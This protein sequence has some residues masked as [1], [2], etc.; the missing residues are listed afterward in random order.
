MNNNLTTTSGPVSGV[1]FFTHSL[2]LGGVSTHMA[3]L[4]AGLM[5][6]GI[7]V[8]IAARELAPGAGF[9]VEYFRDR[10]FEIFQTDFAGYGLTP[11]NLRATWGSVRKVREVVRTF[12]PDLIHV[13]AP[14]LCLVARACGMPYVTTFNIQ[15]DGA[16]KRRIARVANRLLP[17]A[18]GEVSIA[19]S[20][21]LLADMRDGLG[22]PA[23]RI[24][25]TVYTVDE[26]NF[27]PAT[28]E[29]RAAARAHY[30]LPADA[31]VV[32][33]LAAVEPRKNH[34]LLLDALAIAK[35]KGRPIHALMAG[36]DFARRRDELTAKIER[37]GLVDLAR[38]MKHE[39]AVRLYQA[40]DANVLCSRVEGFGLCTVEAMHCGLVPIRTPT[41]GAAELIVDGESGF[42]VPTDDPA[43]LASRLIEL[44]TDADRR[45][46]LGEAARERAAS[47]FTMS[48]MVE[49]TIDAYV[50]C[51]SR[52][53][54]A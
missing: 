54:P 5:Q 14:T 31:F 36:S 34:E 37:D 50:E 15:V 30:G 2:N 8:G 49:Q 18:F 4:G 43:V 3:T 35:A 52:A 33:M 48:R 26:S 24:R 9:G 32:C 41:A 29:Q 40:S 51:V 38:L 46:V 11:A 10:G 47:R 21:E 42:I 1:L 44:A 16:K 13:H 7:R 12:R 20:D 53:R 19:I 39:P 17:T 25:R 28:P 23:S 22:I 6:R 45:R 27:R